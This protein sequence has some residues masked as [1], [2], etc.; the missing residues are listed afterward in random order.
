[1]CRLPGGSRIYP[2]ARTI[3][4]SIPEH[5]MRIVRNPNAFGFKIFAYERKKFDPTS[6]TYRLLIL[7]LNCKK[8]LEMN[9]HFLPGQH[10]DDQKLE[11]IVFIKHILQDWANQ[12]EVAGNDEVLRARDAIAF[13]K[14]NWPLIILSIY[15]TKKGDSYPVFMHHYAISPIVAIKLMIDSLDTVYS[16][17]KFALDD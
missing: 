5:V 11:E 8:R 1:M 13:S 16:Q 15:Q 14:E 9:D 10:Y 7:S 12:G 6:Q 4:M 17:P 2:I 3:I